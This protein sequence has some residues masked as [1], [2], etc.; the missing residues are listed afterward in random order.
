MA[1][2]LPLLGNKDIKTDLILAG[3]WSIS[4]DRA[5]NGQFNLQRLSGDIGLQS[6]GS[7]A[8]AFQMSELQLNAKIVNNQLNVLSHIT[9]PRLGRADFSLAALLD[10]VAMQVAENSAVTMNL[11]S[12]LPDLS[13]LSP[14]MGPAIQLAGS[15]KINVQRVSRAGE[16][17]MTGGIQGKNLSIRD[18]GTGI[19]MTDGE[20]DVV[21]SNQQALLR[22]LRFKG[23]KG[24]ITGSGVIELGRDG[25][26][27]SAKLKA[28]QFTLISKSDM[29]LVMSGQGAI[30]FRDGALQISGQFV[31]DEG[32]IQFVSNEVPRISADVVVLG[33]ERKETS[34][35]LPMT[36]EVNVD[37]GRNFRFRGYGLDAELI[38][39]LRL[40]AQANQ[41][42]RANGTVSVDKGTFRAYGRTLEIERGVLSFIGPIDN[43][44]LDVLAVRRN[45]AVE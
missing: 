19:R 7:A 2:W 11:R 12:D 37:L 20:V 32:D 22:T 9:A 13:L 43:P 38:G 24:D 8:Q 25:P 23:G 14:F 36:I 39:Q 28:N 10:P 33:R 44:G 6:N 3:N 40:R 41:P 18:A 27:G 17:N 42:L 31:A 29:L 5:I 1:D 26:V 16:I 21:L 35:A 30:E 45:Q 15:A 4:Q 34:R